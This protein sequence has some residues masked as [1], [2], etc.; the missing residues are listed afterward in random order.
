MARPQAAAWTSRPS[1]EQAPTSPGPGSTMSP[2][3]HERPLPTSAAILPHF[4]SAR[5]AVLCQTPF[6]DSHPPTDAERNKLPEMNIAKPRLVCLGSKSI[7]SKQDAFLPSRS[8]FFSLSSCKLPCSALER[9]YTRRLCLLT[10]TL[11]WW[12]PENSPSDFF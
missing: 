6:V 9:V 12:C 10:D 3:S 7:G 2:G 8:F 11:R 1:S 5:L 4:Y